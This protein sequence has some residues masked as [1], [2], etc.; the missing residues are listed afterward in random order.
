[1]QGG[2]RSRD[3]RQRI[4]YAM[5]LLRTESMPL[6]DEDHKGVNLSGRAENRRQVVQGGGAER[7]ST[8]GLGRYDKA[9]H[10]QFAVDCRLGW[11]LNQL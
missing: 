11:C 3:F 7:N 1:M 2:T 10:S 4:F 9:R 8:A 6:G 5:R